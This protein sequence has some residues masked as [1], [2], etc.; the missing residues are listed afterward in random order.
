MQDYDFDA[1]YTEEPKH[2]LV[3]VLV[4]PAT[5]VMPDT[6]MIQTRTPFVT[7]MQVKQ[8]RDMAIVERK[9]LRDAALLGDDAFY[10]WGAGKGR[11]EGGSIKLAMAMLGIYGNAA[12]VAEPVQETPEAFY[13]THWFVDLETN[14]ATPK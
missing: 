4:P 2:E 1:E 3:P 8:P 7:S 10:G 14:I 13:F 6:G 9:V 5:P 11:V 12:V